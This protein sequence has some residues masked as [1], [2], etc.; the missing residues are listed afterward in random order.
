[1]SHL[2]ITAHDKIRLPTL[3]TPFDII[4]IDADKKDYI[5]YYDMI[6]EHKLLAQNGIIVADNVLAHGQTVDASAGKD[7]AEL[8]KFN[9]HIAEVTSRYNH[10]LINVGRPRRRLRSSDV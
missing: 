3:H 8:R 5:E 4:F 9:D 6:M 7:S 2:K 1:V 10:M